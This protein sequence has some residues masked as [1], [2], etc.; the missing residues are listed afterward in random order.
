MIHW[1][2]LMRNGERVKRERGGRKGEGG[3]GGGGHTL[4]NEDH[5]YGVVLGSLCLCGCTNL[6]EMNACFASSIFLQ[7]L[8]QSSVTHIVNCAFGLKNHFPTV[9]TSGLS[10]LPAHCFFRGCARACLY[11]LHSIAIAVSFALTRLSCPVCT[12]RYL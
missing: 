5:D 4:K 11:I 6:T 3:G 12:C 7:I 10:S 1:Q 8:Q 2:I 9:C